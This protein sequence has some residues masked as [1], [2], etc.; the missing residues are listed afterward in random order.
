MEK[1]GIR[2]RFTI[3]VVK[4]ATKL[5]K[6]MGRNATHLPGWLANK[7]CPD[8]LGHLEKPETTVYITGTNGKTTVSNLVASVLRENGYDFV[9][10]SSGSNVSEGVISA[11]LDKSTFWGKAKCKLAILE[12]DERY[13]TLIYPYMAPDILLCTNLFRDSYKRNAHSEFI[14]G[15]LDSQIPKHTEL[16]LNGEDLISSHLADGNKRTYFGINCPDGHSSSDNIVKDIVACPKCGSLLDFEY[17]RYNHIGR[18]HCPNCDF[19]SPDM[20]YT[21]ESIDYDKHRCDVKTP[22]GTYNF[23]L[24]GDNVTDIYNEIAAITLLAKLGLSMETI[25]ESFEK[26]E[27]AK[28]RYRVEKV[29]DKEIIFNL[30]KGQNP[31]ACS[32]VCDFISHEPGRKTVV[33][34]FEDFFDAKETSENIAWFY[35]VDFEFLNR[36]D[37]VQIVTA[38]KR[39]QDMHLR[40]LMAGIPEEKISCLDREVDAATKV[41]LEITD[42]VYLLYDV[43][44]MQYADKAYNDLKAGLE[45]G[46]A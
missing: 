26:Q 3:A 39:S 10:N 37:V 15:I 36:E 16:L 24:L 6:L 1:H 5:L 2:F 21:V 4:V 13:S 38:G 45:G 11:L 43:Y 25:N 41:N 31:I 42:K 34:L 28:S 44:T 8:F 9:N 35:D 14:K 30:A 19:G 29:K 20:E 12:V 40:L 46:A 23:K 32:R 18:G 22:E 33:C 17:I 7:L 27:I